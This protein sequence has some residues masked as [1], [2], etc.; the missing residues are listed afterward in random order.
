[1]FDIKFIRVFLLIILLILLVLFIIKFV[2]SNEYIIK[3][4]RMGGEENLFKKGYLFFCYLLV[5]VDY[6]FNDDIF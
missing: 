6:L 3:Y 5:F 4:E 1:M 2:D